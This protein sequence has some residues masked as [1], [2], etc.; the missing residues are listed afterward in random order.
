MLRGEGDWRFGKP[1]LERGETLGLSNVEDDASIAG[2]AAAGRWE[3][4]IRMN[5]NE[6][7]ALAVHFETAAIR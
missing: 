4:N 3:G 7:E 5:R 1:W 2:E 6:K